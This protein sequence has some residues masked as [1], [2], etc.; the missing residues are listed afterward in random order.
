MDLSTILSSNIHTIP[1]FNILEEIIFL[2]LS[3]TNPGFHMSAAQS[4]K[5]TVE[6][7]KIARKEQF[8]LFP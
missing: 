4:F 5:N 7:G 6:K 2:T 8:L 3:Q 1:D